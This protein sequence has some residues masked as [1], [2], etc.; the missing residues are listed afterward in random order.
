MNFITFLKQFNKNNVFPSKIPCDCLEFN[1]KIKN[2]TYNKVP[3]GETHMDI[4]HNDKKIGYVNYRHHNGQIGIICVEKNYRN[5]GVGICT[6][7]K[8]EEEL[9]KNKV[10]TL[11]GITTKDHYFW[12]KYKNIIWSE[13]PHDSVTGSGYLKKLNIK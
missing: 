10:P 2:D 5:K 11:W 8:I 12:S 3:N 4:L 6:L 1:K 7:N 13:R 9:I